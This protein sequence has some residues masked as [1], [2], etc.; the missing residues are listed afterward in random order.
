M[1]RQRRAARRLG[2]VA[3][4]AP[5][6]LPARRDPALLHGS[7]S[8]CS[9]RRRRALRLRLPGDGPHRPA[10]DRAKDPVVSPLVGALLGAA[11]GLGG[12]L[13]VT[14]VLDA[15]RTPIAVRVLPYVRD[16]P[17]P[18]TLPTPV[19]SSN[20][21]AGVFGPWLAAAGRLVERVLGGSASVRRRLQ[22]AGLEMDVAQFR[23]EQVVWGLVAFAIVAVPSGLIAASSPERAVPLLIFCAIAFVLGVLLRENRLTAQVTQRERLIL[24][25]FPTVAELLALAVAAGEGPVAALDR[26]VRRTRGELSAELARVLAKVRTGTPIARAFD[27][28]AARSG[29]AVVS[30]FAEGIAIAV[31]RGTPLADVLHAQAGDVREAGRRALIESGARREVLMMVPVVFLVLPVVVVFAFWPGLVGLRLVVP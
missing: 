21:F 4:A 16:L 27:E 28:L 20:A 6:V 10:A 14:A 22:R 18:D 31:E 15:R 30:R 3:G 5:D 12:W 25:E 7:G 17:R 13:V 1:D 11:L 26:V 19:S 2:A 9:R 23:V 29:L 24:Q 8:R